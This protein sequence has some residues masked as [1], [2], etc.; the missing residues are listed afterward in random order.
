MI[1]RALKRIKAIE[2]CEINVAKSLNM[3]TFQGRCKRIMDIQDQNSLEHKMWLTENFMN[4]KMM[5]LDKT[6]PV[7][8][9]AQK[10][11]LH[12]LSA[13]EYA[14]YFTGINLGVESV[15]ESGLYYRFLSE[16]HFDISRLYD[17]QEEPENAIIAL[18]NIIQTTLREVVPKSGLQGAFKFACS[19]VTSGDAGSLDESAPS[20]GTLIDATSDE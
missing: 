3:N 10:E 13:T 18:E 9:A 6:V 8:L 1:S 20:L 12:R 11:I 15:D 4:S 19:T 2:A 5:P 7:A 17:E 16:F 14:K